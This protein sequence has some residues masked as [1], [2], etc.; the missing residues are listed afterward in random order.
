MSQFDFVGF[1]ALN[2]DKL[3]KADRIA[4]REEESFVTGYHESCGGSA[5]NTTV[6]L[7]RLG[8][9]TGFVG[10]VANDREGRL[11]LGDFKKESVDTRGIV[12][13]KGGQS[14]TV[15][16]FVDKKGDRALYVAP[17]VNDTLDPKE[18]SLDY[19]E[20]AKLLHLTSF[21]GEKSFETQEKLV[22]QLPEHVKVSF[23]PGRLYAERGLSALK[24][25]IRRAYVVLPNEAELKILS[26]KRHEEGAKALVAE[27]AKVVGVKLGNK[28]CF[29]TDG[30]QSHTIAPFKVNVVD[31]TGAGDAWNAG[32]LYGLLKNKSLNECGILGNLVASRCI[33]QMGARTGLPRLA[34]LEIQKL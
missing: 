9:E 27:G 17:G 22:Q 1:G 3:F 5:A 6:G 13:A 15:M 28:G 21:A 19:V 31:T 7:A 12:V 10:K 33:M 11:L 29:V 2:I 32:F 23:D 8:L 25:I 16:G 4:G 30:E 20:R 14:G 18:I 34:E 26:G 24:P